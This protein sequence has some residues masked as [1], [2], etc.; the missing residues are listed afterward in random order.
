MGDPRNLQPHEVE[1]FATR[2]LRKSGL[3]LLALKRHSQTSVSRSGDE[4]VVELHGKLRVAGV[5]VPVVVEC[6]N[7]VQPIG[8]PVVASLHSRLASVPA[9]HAIL[10]SVS[11]Y[12]PEAIRVA[13]NAGIA[14]LR[15]TDGK[16]AFARSRSGF[17]GQPPA[18]VPEYMAEVLDQDAAG[19]VRHELVVAS[20][21]QL[22]LDRFNAE[23]TPP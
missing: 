19:A 12:S 7:A 6:R 15:V 4:Y 2:E 3:E 8:A 22:I 18:W 9:R 14:L 5:D 21:P 17:A 10:F 20:R 11:D 23:S 1:I 13:R 16:T